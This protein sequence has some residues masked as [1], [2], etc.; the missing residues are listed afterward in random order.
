VPVR[1][2]ETKRFSD[3][4]GWFAEAY[5][6]D[7]F[8]TLGVDVDFVQDNH[9]M[10]RTAGVLRGLHFQ[11]PPHAQAKLV[12]CVRGAIW[13]VAVDLRLGSPTFARWVACVLSADNGLQL[14]IP[15]GFAHGFVTLEPDAEVEYKASAYYAPECEGGLSWDDPTLDIPWPLAGNR[16]N[17]SDKDRGLPTLAEF[18]SPFVYD[19]RPLTPLDD[20]P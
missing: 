18:A 2:I 7:R 4:R 19:G 12:R 3:A 20:A 13:D 10:S 6:R 5:N 16:P 11:R 15:V 1:L 17:L 8:A 14:F 9:S